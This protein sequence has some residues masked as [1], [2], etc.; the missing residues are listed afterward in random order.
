V[1]KPFYAGWIGDRYTNWDPD[2]I[3]FWVA[4]DMVIR[5]PCMT[6]AEAALEAGDLV[7]L[8]ATSDP[9]WDPKN[10]TPGVAGR[11][12]AYSSGSPENIVGRCI[13]KVPIGK[14]A[15]TSAG[16]SLQTAIGTGAP[17][18]LFN[19][20]PTYVNANIEANYGGVQG[21]VEGVPGLALGGTS[22]VL[23]RPQEML[24]AKADS[25]GMFWAVDILVRV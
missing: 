23:G 24:F 9:E 6:G 19:F 22:A 17:R 10:A 3:A 14:Q 20:D 5:V 1:A 4:K 18:T 13:R 16:Q 2:A 7:E 11:V 21:K 15:A 12:T 8:D 25:N